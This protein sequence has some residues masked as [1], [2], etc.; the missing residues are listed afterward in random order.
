[1]FVGAGGRDPVVSVE[2]ARAVYDAV[3]AECVFVVDA[4]LGHEPSL[5]AWTALA[6]AFL[7]WALR[8]PGLD[9]NVTA[10]AAELVWGG[11]AGEAKEEEE[12]MV[13]G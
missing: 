8:P 4:G 9:A 11:R 3:G 12:E 5:E 7:V 1:V 2:D 6:T 10:A 13:V